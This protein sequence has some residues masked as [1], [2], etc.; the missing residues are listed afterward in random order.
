MGTWVVGPWRAIGWELLPKFYSNEV[1]WTP[2]HSGVMYLTQLYRATGDTEVRKVCLGHLAWSLDYCQF[3][4]GAIGAHSKDDKWLGATGAS[5]TE[6]VGFMKANML[7]EDYANRYRPNVLKALEFLKKYSTPEKVP[8]DGVIFVTNESTPEPDVVVTMFLAWI[9]E[10]LLD[11][12][13]LE[14]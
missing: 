13:E 9:V 10:G 5:I 14:K 2:N 8:K 6:Y 1:G 7:D 11:G 3:D 4:D 12:L